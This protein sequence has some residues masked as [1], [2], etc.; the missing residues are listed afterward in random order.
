MHACIHIH[1]HTCRH[2]H[3]IHYMMI[4]I[5][6]VHQLLKNLKLATTARQKKA[7][8]TML[9]KVAC[10]HHGGTRHACAKISFTLSLRLGSNPP[11][12][13]RYRTTLGWPSLTALWRQFWA[14]LSMSNLLSPNLG[15]RYLTISKWPPIAARWRAF[16]R[17]YTL[18]NVRAITLL[19]E[20][21]NVK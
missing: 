1:T 8:Q 7:V 16:R 17:S 21:V 11:S 19:P 12:S 20:W 10:W 5:V 2:T 6:P 18:D 3:L 9:Y 15:M 13:M 4:H 14:R